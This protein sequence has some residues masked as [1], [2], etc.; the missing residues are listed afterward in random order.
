MSA[1]SYRNSA[2]KIYYLH[3]KLVTL[4]GGKK[5]N[6]YYFARDIR[7]GALNKIPQGYKVVETKRSG[8]PVLKR[9]K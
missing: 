6:I 9:K 2:G 3:H 4:K 1:Y 7:D 8:L 5:Q